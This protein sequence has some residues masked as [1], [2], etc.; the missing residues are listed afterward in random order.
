MF[1][2]TLPFA[3]RAFSSCMSMS[4]IRLCLASSMAFSA[5]PPSPIPSMPGGHHPAPIVG[6]VF[7]TQ[8][9]TES[10]GFNITNFDF[11]SDPPPLAATMTST[12]PPW[13][14]LTST[15]HGVLSLVFFRLNA[16]SARIDPRSL[17]SG[18]S[19]ASRT[20]WSHISCRL[21]DGLPPSLPVSRTSM[22]SLMKMR[23]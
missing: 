13:T 6:T 3:A 19:H 8:S 17:L 22:P 7:S 9:T 20:P 1:V 11:A 15:T 16:G 2:S 4:S 12:V 18:S 14:R 23:L 21:M 10:D 5:V